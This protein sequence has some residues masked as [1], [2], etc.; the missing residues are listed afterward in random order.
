M[1]KPQT[2]DDYLAQVAPAQREL[3]TQLRTLILSIQPD[4]EECIS[5]AKPAF[6]TTKPF[7]G[8]YASKAHC[9]FV[10]FSGTTM[11]TCA[12]ELTGYKWSPGGVQFAAANPL[13]E[14]LI[15]KI[16]ATR[17]KEIADT[18]K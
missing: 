4:A 1:P 9:I 13:P 6:R 14:A 11:K 7:A 2:H 15:R 18:G 8:Y 16:I 17:L 5:Y 3:L 10:S 12:S